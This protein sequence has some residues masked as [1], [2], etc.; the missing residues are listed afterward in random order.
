MGVGGGSDSYLERDV[1]GQVNSHTEVNE[2][3]SQQIRGCTWVNVGEEEGNVQFWPHGAWSNGCTTGGMRGCFCKDPAAARR[4]RRTLAESGDESVES[5]AIVVTLAESADES[6]SSA[7]RALT[8]DTPVV[9]PSS[10]AG[11][12]NCG[13][14]TC[15]FAG[16]FTVPA[17]ETDV[18][19]YAFAGCAQL[20][21]VVFEDGT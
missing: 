3:N 7:R 9:W 15:T 16:T 13:N 21:G 12:S 20:T 18:P 10:C 17:H 14:A 4:R 6:V 5:N 11:E 1:D 2:Q 19:K 8:D